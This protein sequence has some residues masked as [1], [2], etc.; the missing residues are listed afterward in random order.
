MLNMP[1][2][3]IEAQ[4]EKEK[5]ML[6]DFIEKEFD[7]KVT[8]TQVPVA[9][10]RIPSEDECGAMLLVEFEDHNNFETAYNEHNAT[11]NDDDWPC[12]KLDKDLYLK[13]ESFIKENDFLVIDFVSTF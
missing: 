6:V 3:D 1:T 2:L 12:G 11:G 9:P 8:D 7:R 10:A 4:L 13:C 5:K